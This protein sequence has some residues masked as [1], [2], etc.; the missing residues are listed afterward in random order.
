MDASERLVAAYLE[1]QGFHSI[2]FEPD[3]NIPPDFLCDGRVAVE[4]RRLDQSYDCGRKIKSL[5]EVSIP[6]KDQIS[7][8][9]RSLEPAMHNQ[10]WFVHYRFSRP[11]PKKRDLEFLVKNEL[12]QFTASIESQPFGKLIAP[13]FELKVS[14][15]FEIH[16]T[17]FVLAG[18]TD[19]EASGWV[20]ESV[21]ENLK[22]CIAEKI[23]KTAKFRMR[24]PEWWLVMPDRVGYSLNQWSR[25]I[26]KRNLLLKHNFNKVV[27]LDPT[28]CSRSFQ[29]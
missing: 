2:E 23:V 26:L 3:G 16:P 8:I 25:S 9:L 28:N 10:S 5:E 4:V 27:L 22:R 7:R 11:I 18:Y 21:G 1:A 17:F 19:K 13:R 29:L 24:Y 15:C 12:V 20:I 14:R 6:L